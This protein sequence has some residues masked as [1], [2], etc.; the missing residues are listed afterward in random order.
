[1]TRRMS[2]SAPRSVP[3][4]LLAIGVAA[5]SSGRTS[6]APAP[7][8]EPAAE[9]A[10]APAQP[11]A[12]VAGAQPVAPFIAEQQLT[13]PQLRTVVYAG[14][15]W[16]EP[17]QRFHKAVQAG[18]LDAALP[19]VRFVEYD[20]D[21]AKAALAADGYSARLIPLFALPRADGHASERV[22]FGSIKGEGAVGNILPRLQ[23]LLAGR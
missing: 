1:V 2:R 5:C 21:T 14:A 18:E 6:P 16:C 17:C 11:P 9:Q 13:A 8:A 15:A 23:A 12:F 19:N 3:A 22:I 7:A 4:L 20:Y 10:P